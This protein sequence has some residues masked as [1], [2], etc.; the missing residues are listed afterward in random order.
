ME[1]DFSNLTSADI[2]QLDPQIFLNITAEQL[3]RIPPSVRS[4]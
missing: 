2:A 4:S 1:I 3:A